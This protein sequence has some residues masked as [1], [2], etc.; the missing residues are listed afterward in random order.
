[1]LSTE[2]TL[3]GNAA[4]AYMS[5][6]RLVAK[7][8]WDPFTFDAW[9]RA[10]AGLTDAQR[11]NGGGPNPAGG[12]P[13][14]AYLIYAVPY[15]AS[16]GDGPFARLTAMR[17]VSVL[18]LLVTVLGTWL[19]AGET[20]G[21]R[22]ELQVVAAAVPALAPLVTFISS[23]VT[24]DAMLIA[25]WTLAFWL[26]VRMLSRGLTPGRGA[27]LMAMVGIACVVKTTSYALLPGALLALGVAL[28]RRR[29][30]GAR[31]LA[32][33]AAA[34][35]AALAVCIAPWF[36]A[37]RLLHH[38][39]GAQLVQA[40]STAGTNW[41]QF[42][43][44]LW[45]FYL[46]KLPFMSEFRPPST[47]LPVYDVLVKGVIGRFGWLE[48]TFVKQ[49]YWL[50]SVLALAVLVAAAVALW[51][52]RRSVD[53]A[54]A[55]FFAIPTVILMAVLHWEEYHQL[56]NRGTGFIQGRYLLPLVGLAGLAAAQAVRLLPRARRALGVAGMV[57]LL[58][59]LQFLALGLVLKRFYA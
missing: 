40:T 43:S 19:L 54:V 47:R 32:P 39:A 21:R 25:T 30:D 58:F 44:Y 13:P 53:L 3:A 51:R 38:K 59:A 31:G 8:T 23:S 50:V 48:V 12:N 34:S 1:V 10:Q 6:G 35:L 29:A 26:G 9:K 15:A 16:A 42:A 56:L 46:P 5:N 27:A 57:S 24:P 17:L 18:W 41:H 33:A 20:F 36:V 37:A 2:Q 7:P 45:Q 52:R 49:L 4:N 55:A 22:P 11:T 14:L 28:W